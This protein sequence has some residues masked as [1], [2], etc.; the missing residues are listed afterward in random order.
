MV[1]VELDH[2]LDPRKIEDIHS[3]RFLSGKLETT[4]DSNVSLWGQKKYQL[5]KKRQR[6]ILNTKKDKF[7][8]VKGS[9]GWL[10]HD[11]DFG[12]MSAILACYNNHWVL[13]T[14][15]DDWWNVIIRNVAQAVDD[16]GDKENVKKFFVSH[17]EKKTIDIEVPSL[18]SVD[19]SWLFSQFSKGIRENIKVPGYVDVYQAD[20]STS[21]P[22]QLI[23]SQIMLMSSMQ[24]YFEYQFGTRCG[25]P[26]VQMEGQLEDWQKLMDKTVRLEEMLQPVMGDLDLAKWFTNCK[27]ILGKLVDTYQG[28]PDKEWWG[29]VL[30]HNERH[31]SGGKEWWTGWIIDFLNVQKDKKGTQ[32]FSSGMVSVPVTV[33]QNQLKD[34]GELSAGTIGFNVTQGDDQVG[35]PVVE[36]VQG[37]ALV[38]PHGSVLTP[39]LRGGRPIQDSDSDSEEK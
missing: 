14:S 28:K 5:S 4:D 1:Y 18:E 8:W 19:Y 12:F 34:T 37:W 9:K 27:E 33:Y 23:A 30:C 15:P 16:N 35:R 20:F 26:G 11:K 36:S 25:V 39:L 17:E 13:K 3:T 7:E 22:T 6:D 24:K 32:T 29:H 38:M 31:G 2:G 21:T 10:W